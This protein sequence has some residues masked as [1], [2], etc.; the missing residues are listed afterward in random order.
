MSASGR[1]DRER[2]KEEYKE[3]YRKIRNAKEKLRQTSYAKKA[4]D[5][6]KQMQ[7]DELLDSVDHFLGKLRHKM[8]SMEAR[9]DQAMDDI[10]TSGEEEQEEMDEELRKENAKDTIRQIKLEMGMLYDDLEKQAEE[11]KVQKTVGTSRQAGSSPDNEKS[12]HS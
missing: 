3:H 5:A 7:A 1:E 6:V 8:A 9:L 4:S 2:L 11:M 12:G 10:I